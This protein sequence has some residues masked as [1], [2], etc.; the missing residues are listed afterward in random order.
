M[1]EISMKLIKNHALTREL[2]R[3]VF[4]VDVRVLSSPSHFDQIA[5]IGEPHPKRDSIARA[6]IEYYARVHPRDMGLNGKADAAAIT[7][8]RREIKTQPPLLWLLLRTERRGEA[9]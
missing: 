3:D 1:A 6:R 5:F 9:D 8:E 7:D 2:R 4:G